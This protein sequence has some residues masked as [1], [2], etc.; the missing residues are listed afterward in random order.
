MLG[1]TIL[2]FALNRRW[3]K[4]TLVIIGILLAWWA[5]DYLI[6]RPIPNVDV[7]TQAQY[8]SVLGKRFRTQHD[9]T[10][11]GYTMDRN[12]KKQIDYIALVEPPGFS[13]PEVVAKA[14][15]PKGALL[16]VVAILKADTWLV[17]RVQYLVKRVDASPPL[18]GRMVLKVDHKS[19]RN[20]GLAEAVFA[21]INGD[22]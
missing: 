5:L 6:A 17:D 4:P 7:S 16:E 12:Y 11:V 22:A 19:P 14:Q 8:V 2:R 9:L 18:D 3:I 15:L 20:F 10:A 13:G 1:V 21:P